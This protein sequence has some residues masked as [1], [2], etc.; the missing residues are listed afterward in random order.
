[1]KATEE[2][3][4][5]KSTPRNMGVGL[6]FLIA[7]VTGNKG[8]VG[9]YSGRGV[10]YSYRSDFTGNIEKNASVRNAAYPGTLVD[11][12]LKTDCFVGDDTEEEDMKW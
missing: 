6:D 12:T 8:N 1:M 5:T 2:G 11:L 4:T 3:F 7:T 9:I 10:L